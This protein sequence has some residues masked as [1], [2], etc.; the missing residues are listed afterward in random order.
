MAISAGLPRKGIYAF[1]RN[2]GNDVCALQ[3]LDS[4]LIS[5]L[6]CYHRRKGGSGNAPG[7]YDFGIATP[8]LG[9]HG[10]SGRRRVVF[11]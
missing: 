4:L 2:M 8:L 7:S 6:A 1:R 9:Q 5:I 11:E 3:H 10:Q